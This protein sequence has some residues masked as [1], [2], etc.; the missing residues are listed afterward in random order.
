M[1]I[2]KNAWNVRPGG[3]AVEDAFLLENPTVPDIL[4][5]IVG[6]YAV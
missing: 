3:I 4:R 6:S 5:N 1:H 2:K